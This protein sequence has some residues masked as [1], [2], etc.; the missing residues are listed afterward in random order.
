[1][2]A[3]SLKEIQ[4][5]INQAKILSDKHARALVGILCKR[6]ELLEDEEQEQRR[7]QNNPNLKLLTPSLYKKLVKEIIYEHNRAFKDLLDLLT[8]PTLEVRKKEDNK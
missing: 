6:V 7:K 5:T 1:M 3:K 4:E 8:I 2:D